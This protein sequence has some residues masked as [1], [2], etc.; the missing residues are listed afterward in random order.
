M[1][2][3]LKVLPYLVVG[4]I[5]AFFVCWSDTHGITKFLFFLILVI[6]LFTQYQNYMFIQAE[7]NFGIREP[8]SNNVAFLQVIAEIFIIIFGLIAIF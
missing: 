1:I 5:I 6:W 2:N 8:N 7:N 4:S 3:L